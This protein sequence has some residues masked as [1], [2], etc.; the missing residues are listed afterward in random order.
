M[1]VP[2]VMDDD[3]ASAEVL[4]A[5][6]LIYEYVDA[7]LGEAPENLPWDANLLKGLAAPRPV[8]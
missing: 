7:Q 4:C 6:E 8:V 1:V 3:L 5:G 2:Q